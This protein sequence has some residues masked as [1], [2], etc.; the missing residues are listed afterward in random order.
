M[1]AVDLIAFGETI[2]DA[3]RE[4]VLSIIGNQAE[5]NAM[6]SVIAKVV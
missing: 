4:S 6:E 1:D 2:K 5:V 3:L